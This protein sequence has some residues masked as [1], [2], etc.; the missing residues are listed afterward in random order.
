VGHLGLG[1]TAV[2]VAIGAPHRDDGAFQAARYTID[3]IK[4]IVPIWKKEG[5]A[6]GE[7]WLDGDYQ[8]QAGE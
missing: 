2:L 8:P 6:D 5:W 3:R 1:E 4:E 7:E